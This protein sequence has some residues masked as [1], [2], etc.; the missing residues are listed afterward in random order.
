MPDGVPEAVDDDSLEEEDELEHDLRPRLQEALHR[1]QVVRL[2]LP[3]RLA[4]G[5][6]QPATNEG[7]H[8]TTNTCVH[9][10]PYSRTCY[11][12]AA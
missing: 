12:S 1:A 8:Y 2:R 7:V 6:D 11:S 3:P 10:T 9:C 4:V 5:A